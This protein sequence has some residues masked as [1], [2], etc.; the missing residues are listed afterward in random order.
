MTNGS[1]EIELRSAL[2]AHGI[3]R[4]QFVKFCST[5]VGTLALPPRYLGAVVKAL[6]KTTRPVLVCWS[7]RIAPATPNPCC[8]PA[9]PPS[10]IS[11][12]IFFRGN[13]TS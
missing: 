3:S 10:A 6:D 11:F 2:E 4:R 7:F 9:T 12:L 13:T 1:S 5:M 8:A